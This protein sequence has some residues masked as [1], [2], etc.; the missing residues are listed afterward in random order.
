MSPPE[1]ELD[2]HVVTGYRAGEEQPGRLPV[3]LA[4]VVL[5]IQLYHEFQRRDPKGITPHHA[6]GVGYGEDQ[7]DTDAARQFGQQVYTAIFTAAEVTTAAAGLPLEFV[8]DDSAHDYEQQHLPEGAWPPTGWYADWASGLD[9]FDLPRHESPIE[10]RWLVYRL[11][12][13]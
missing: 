8:T 7:R 2:F 12:C 3:T 6:T 9:V 1:I 11:S 4:H 13:E 5:S 10:L